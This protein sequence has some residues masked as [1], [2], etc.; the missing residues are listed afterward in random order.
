MVIGEQ[1]LDSVRKEELDEQCGGCCSQQA[2]LDEFPGFVKDIRFLMAECCRTR[3][4]SQASSAD[5]YL[6]LVESA[7]VRPAG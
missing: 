2:I 4:N 5:F 3:T 7:P 6:D 1:E